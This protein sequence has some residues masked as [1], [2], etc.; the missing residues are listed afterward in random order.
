[1]GSL[2][3][4]PAHVM[5]PDCGPVWHGQS[6]VGA[7]PCRRTCRSRRQRPVPRRKIWSVDVAPCALAFWDRVEC[8]NVLEE[9]KGSPHSGAGARDHA[10]VA[11][12][13][14]NAIIDNNPFVTLDTAEVFVKTH[15]RTRSNGRV[16][17]HPLTPP[18]LPQPPTHLKHP[19]I[20]HTYSVLQS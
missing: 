16:H 1:M 11:S 20:H 13:R 15:A 10:G 8:P 12:S 9:R 2:Q 7:S 3:C 18:P 5:Y 4:V 14:P 17:T 19:H 6:S